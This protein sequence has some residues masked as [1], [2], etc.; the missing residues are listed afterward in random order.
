MRILIATGGTGGHI[1]PALRVAHEMRTRGHE[2]IF[3]GVL[4]MAE[5]QILS[6]GFDLVN[7]RATG[8]NSKTIVGIAKFTWIMLLA[9][10]RSVGIIKGIKPDKVIGFGGYG[11]FPIIFM[12]WLMRYPIMIHEQNVYPGKANRVMAYFAK[13]IAISFKDSQQYFTSSKVVFT[14]CPC[15][16]RVSTRL[17]QEIR[18]QFGIDPYKMTILLLGGS[19]GSHQLNEVFYHFMKTHGESGTLQAIHMTGKAEYEQYAKR[20]QQERLP[21]IVCAFISNID[22]AYAACDVVIARAGASSVTEIGLLGIPSV[23]VPYPFAGGH[24]KYNAMVLVNAKAARMIDQD[25]LT[26]QTLQ[27][28]L[29][30]IITAHES[31]TEIR[32][33][34]N[35]ILFPDAVKRLADVL[36]SL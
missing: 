12:A 32:N 10:I 2:V 15:N 35:G 17:V 26:V 28:A 18:A 13:R 27:Q 33:K 7:I 11:S 19:Q 6:A 16:S 36:E 5:D 30:D 31:R 20:Y 29:K 14:G 25:N 3:A 1:F 4:G 23:F 34:T 8:F 9:M 21:G 24:Q 22:D